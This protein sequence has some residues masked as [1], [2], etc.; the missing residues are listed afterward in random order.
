MMEY[1]KGNSMV[2]YGGDAASIWATIKSFY[3]EKLAGSYVLYKGFASVFPYTWLYKLSLIFNVEQFTFIRM[4]HSILFAYITTI[5]FPNFISKMLKIEIKVWRKILLTF[6]L[7]AMWEF[8][9]V[10]SQLM[11]DLPSLAYFLLALN[12]ALRAV[13]KKGTIK[14]IY[15]TIAG[16]LVGLVNNISGQYILAGTAILVYI[17]YKNITLLI[18]NKKNKL[19]SFTIFPIAC[20]LISVISVSAI[21]NQ[22]EKKIVD[23]L[24]AQ[25]EWIPDKNTWLMFGLFNFDSLTLFPEIPDNL[26]KAIKIKFFGEGYDTNLIGYSVDVGNDPKVFI[27]MYLDMVLTYPVEFIVR[28]FNRFF[29]ALSPANNNLNIKMLFIDYSAL[30]L[31]LLKIKKIKTVKEFFS[32]FLFLWLAF[33]LAIVPPVVM[34]ME[35]R[36]AIQIQGL[37][38]SIVVLDDYLWTKVKNFVLGFKD[39]ITKFNWEKILDVRFSPIFFVYLLFIILCFSYIGTLYEMIGPLGDSIFFHW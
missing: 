16:L 7:F 3:A 37:I 1:L 5:G 8:T 38:F 35:L 15:Y 33:P 10:F 25:G 30:F 19:V 2:S 13:E 32:P 22:F 23:P 9:D 14:L 20:L 29:I 39:L 17:V 18:S 6:V 21:N 24:R 4:Y 34:H 11:V 36:Y 26:G 31:V 12:C 28:Y 27:P